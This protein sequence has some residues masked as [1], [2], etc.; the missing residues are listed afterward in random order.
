MPVGV[1]LYDGHEKGVLRAAFQGADVVADGAEVYLRAGAALGGWRD[2]LQ[3]G[4]ALPAGVQD[5][6]G[7]DVH[8][9]DDAA[10]GI[11]LGDG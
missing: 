1:R 11:V 6:E 8:A 2:G 10:E 4:F 9:G 5:V 3:G 7:Q